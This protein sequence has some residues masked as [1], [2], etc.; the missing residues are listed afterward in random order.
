LPLFRLFCCFSPLKLM[1][2]SPLLPFHFPLQIIIFI[3]ISSILH[4]RL[5]ISFHY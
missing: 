1:P 4:F 3:F 5:M 2:F